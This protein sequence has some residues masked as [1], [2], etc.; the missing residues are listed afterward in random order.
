MRRWL[1]NKIT[2]FTF[3]LDTQVAEQLPGLVYRFT[4]VVDRL[5]ERFVWDVDDVL[6]YDEA[7]ELTQD[8]IDRGDLNE[9]RFEFKPQ[10]GEITKAFYDGLKDIHEQGKPGRTMPPFGPIR[11]TP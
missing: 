1:A 4:N 8:L 10:P 3:W 2:G 9:N 6:T 7:A 11:G 5:V